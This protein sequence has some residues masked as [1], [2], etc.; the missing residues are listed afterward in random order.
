MMNLYAQYI[1]E[2]ENKNLVQ[3]AHGFATYQK[4][5]AESYYIVDIFVEKG[6]RKNGI[7]SELSEAVRK[8]AINDGASKLFGSVDIGTNGVTE[9]MAAIIAN[10]FKYSHSNGNMIYFVKLLGD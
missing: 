4:I 10:G 2:R 6:F 5:D 3:V 8:I 9:S 7:A 1:S